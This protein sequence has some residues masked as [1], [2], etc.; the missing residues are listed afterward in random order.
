MKNIISASRRTD[1]PAFYSEWFIRRLKAGEVYVKNPYGGQIYRV[2]LK[3]DDIHCIVFWSKNFAPLISRIEEVENVTGNLFFHFTI[4][5]IPEDIESNTPHYTEAI[6]D[7]ICLSKRYSP[8]HLIWRFDPVCITDKLSF[9]YY[10]EMFSECAE[11][12]RGSCD[13]CYISF[14]QKYRKA[15][16]NF[17]KY[18]DHEF[19]DIDA[20]TQR[21]YAIRLSR[22]AEK[23]GIKLYACCND[24]LLSDQVHKGSCINS[25]ELAELFSD[26]SISTPVAPTR[27]EC[28]C[29]KSIDI[30][31]YDTCPHGCLYCYANSDKEKSK[32]LFKNMEMG[33]NALGFN[34]DEEITVDRGLQNSLF[35]TV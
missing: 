21:E 34:V 18:S 4:T 12:L 24:Y 27:K 1:I 22:I 26:Y 7:F 30:G 13:K 3:P 23:N 19:V 33:W 32:A 2:S 35:N 10:E 5:G 17:E 8:D 11:K 15:I 28:A 14:V 31:S 16:S 9:D 20:Q 6:D 29:T 25:R